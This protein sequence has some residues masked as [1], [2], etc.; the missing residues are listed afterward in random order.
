MDKEKIKEQSEKFRQSLGDNATSNVE[1]IIKAEDIKEAMH[2]S[3]D[4]IDTS[5]K[6]MADLQQVKSMSAEGH[7]DTVVTNR[8]IGALNKLAAIMSRPVV[9]DFTLP[10]GIPDFGNL[11]TRVQIVKMLGSEKRRLQA[12]ASKGNVI[13]FKDAILESTLVSIG[14]KYFNFALLKRHKGKLNVD[15]PEDAE[16]I[17]SKLLSSIVTPDRSFIMWQA[18]QLGNQKDDG[19]SPILLNMPCP[20]CKYENKFV[21][22]MSRSKFKNADEAGLFFDP[23]DNCW[24]KEEYCEEFDLHFIF[25]LPDSNAQNNLLRLMSRDK[26]DEGLSELTEHCILSIDGVHRDDFHSKFGFSISTFLDEADDK[27]LG[28]IDLKLAGLNP[29]VNGRIVFDCQNDQCVYQ[30]DQEVNVESFLFQNTLTQI[31]NTRG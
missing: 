6:Y 9:Y 2:R 8:K 21:F 16:N 31:P 28:W 12:I 5:R 7:E 1:N 23:V 27:L 25:R 22:D 3:D 26:M 19:T 13:A 17:D 14:D 4:S 11:L 30:F 18:I 15:I 24:K 29:S 20:S 10:C